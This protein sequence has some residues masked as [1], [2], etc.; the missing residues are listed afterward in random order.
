MAGRNLPET[1]SYY[2]ILEGASTTRPPLFN[3]DNYSYSKKRM[4]YFIQAQNMSAWNFITDGDYIP[5][6]MEV[7]LGN[8]VIPHREYTDDILKKLQTNASTTN[9]LHC[10]L[11]ATKY[12]KVSSCETAKDIWNKLEVTYEATCKVKQ[13]KINQLMRSYELFE[14]FEKESISDMN[15]RFTKIVNDLK[16]LGK[17]IEEP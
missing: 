11:S 5:V 3:G 9:M 7:G 1:F 6:R 16:G 8:V 2:M 15:S 17:D 13:S 12:N 4:M 10:A 14:M